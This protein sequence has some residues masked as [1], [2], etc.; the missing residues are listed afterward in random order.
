MEGLI[1]SLSGSVTQS[2]LMP[3]PGI[4]GL[5][6]RDQLL[7]P[8]SR[9]SN[10][11]FRDRDSGFGNNKY[12]RILYYLVAQVCNDQYIG[13]CDNLIKLYYSQKKTNF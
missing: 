12:S 2:G 9:L 7:N 8:E 4:S 5:G 6:I 11:D 10:P 3:I 1:Q 13:N